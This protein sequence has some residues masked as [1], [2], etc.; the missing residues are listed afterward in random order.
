MAASIVI[1]G[2]GGHAAVVAEAAVLSGMTLAGHL[3]PQPGDDTLLGAHLGDDDAIAGLLAAGHD[4]AIG[5]GFVNAAGAQRRAKVLA[6]LPQDRLAMIA[7]PSAVIS[8]SGQIGAG[9][10]A[11]AGAI[12]GTRSRAAAGLLLNS[13]AIIDHD[14]VIGRNC[15]VATGA[16]VSGGVVMGDNVLIGTGASV[17]QGIRIGDNAVIGA[18]AVVVA[19]VPVGATVVGV[20]ARDLGT[21]RKS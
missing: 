11:A 17:R 21:E 1:L 12:F 19:D 14:C 7:H 4:L 6:M 15:H 5:F 18:G 13:G 9:G 8:P 2:A 10:F 20:P 16:K 3:A